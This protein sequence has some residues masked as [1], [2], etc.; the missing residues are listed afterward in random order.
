MPVLQR[1][2]ARLTTQAW[3]CALGGGREFPCAPINSLRAVFD[4]HAQVAHLGMVQSM[5]HPSAGHVRVVRTPVTFS[6]V[7]RVIAL[8]SLP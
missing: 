4:E 6:G 7:S 1:K 2:F 3:M 8:C 5:L